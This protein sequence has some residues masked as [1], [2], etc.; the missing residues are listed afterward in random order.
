MS[1]LTPS[2]KEQ[3]VYQGRMLEVVNQAMSDGSRTIT[4]EWARRAP[5]IRLLLVDKE[6]QTV[7]L[8]R[9]HRYELGRDDYRLPGGKVFDSLVEYNDFLKSGKDIVVP[10]TAKAKAE[11][12]EEVGAKV[13]TLKHFHTST[14]G[15]T[16]QWDLLYFEAIS[17]QLESQQLEAG[18]QISVVETGF[19]E[20]QNMALG[21]QMSEERS[22][23]ILLRY[24]Q[25]EH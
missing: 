1:Q 2:G 18:E 21:G 19:E 22:A 11:A 23:L 24:L 12:L 7:L 4:F 5:G 17:W 14:C 20:A 6:K 3:I 25:T 8:T 16:V 9:E 13:E 10:A 15:A